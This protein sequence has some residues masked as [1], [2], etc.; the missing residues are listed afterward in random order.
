[1]EFDFPPKRGSGLEKLMPNVSRDTIDLLYR[2]LAYDPADRITADEALK[3]EYFA[4][5]HDLSNSRDFRS[6]LFMKFSESDTMHN[7]QTPE[8]DRSVKK[9][10]N[11]KII[12]KQISKALIDDEQTL[13]PIQPIHQVGV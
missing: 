12:K 6:T 10:K 7:E 2:L 8:K 4:E 1:M 5:L 13:P 3:H 9:S 11:P